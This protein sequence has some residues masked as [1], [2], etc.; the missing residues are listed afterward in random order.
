MPFQSYPPQLRAEDNFRLSLFPEH[1]LCLWNTDAKNIIPR[2]WSQKKTKDTHKYHRKQYNDHLSI[3]NAAFLSDDSP[4]ELKYSDHEGIGVY[5]KRDITISEYNTNHRHLLIG[6]T[7]NQIDNSS[8]FS[9]VSLIMKKRELG[10]PKKDRKHTS[11]VF[12]LYGPISFV[13]HACQSKHATFNLRQDRNEDPVLCIRK[14]L[15]EGD[16]VTISY[17]PNYPNVRCNYCWAARNKSTKK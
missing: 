2:S 4:F 10:R 16:Q 3:L 11:K 9:D 7:M 1:R 17:G 14:N 5:C 8:H 6:F 13:N 15:K 12:S